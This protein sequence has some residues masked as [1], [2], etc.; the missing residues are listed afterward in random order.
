MPVNPIETRGRSRRTL[1]ATA[2]AV[3]VAVAAVGP[4]AL[5]SAARAADLPPQEAGFTLR[6]YFTPPLDGLCVLKSGQT[7]NVDKLGSTIDLT[8]KSQFLGTD[9]SQPDESF[10][11]EALANLTV[12]TDGTY[13]FRLTSDDGSRLSIDGGTVIDHDGKHAASPKVGS[14]GLAA[15]VH[16][17]RVDY[18]DSGYDAILKLEWKRPGASDWEIVPQSAL[19]TEAGVVR[20][21]APGTKY[22]EGATDTAGD[23]LRLDAVNPNYTLVDIRPAGFDP[24]VSGLDFTDDGRLAL[25]TTGDVSAGGWTPNPRSGELYLLDGVQTATGPADVTA[26][27]VAG[28]LFNPMGVDVIGDKIY[29]AER[30]QLSELTD[31]DGDGQY[32]VKTTVAQWA[33]GGNFHEFAFGLIH[34][35]ENFYLNLSVAINNGGATT[36]PQPGGSHRG[37]SIKVNRATG[38]VTYAAG[39]LRT[40]NGIAF[41]PDGDRFAMDNQGAWNPGNKLVHVQDGHFYNQFITPAGDY[42]DRAVTPPALWIPQNEIGNSPTTPIQLH[43]GPFA[44][45]MLWGDLTYGGLQR[46][47]LEKVDGE[48]QG[49]VFRHSAGFEVGVNR[50][51]ETDDGTLYVGGTGEG[52]NWGESN[53]LRYGLQKLV[54]ISQ[55]SSFEIATMKAVAGGFELTYTHPLSQETVDGIASSYSVRQWRYVPTSQYGG[56]NV[57]EE[58][59][60]VHSANVSEDRRTVTIAIDGLKEGH[61]VHVRSPRPFSSEGGTELWSTEAWYTLNS[62]PGVHTPTTQGWYEAEQQSLLPGGAKVESEHNGYSGTGFVAGFDNLGTG[63]SFAVTVPEAGVYP[64]NVR[65]ANGPHPNPNETKDL[66]LQVNGQDAGTVSL[67]TTNAWNQW[68]TATRN[69]TLAAGLNN[70]VLRYAAGTKGHVN[71]DAL[72][73]GEGRSDVCAA[74]SVEDGYTALFDGTLASFSAW[75]MAGPGSFGRVADDCSL[76][77]SG[78]LGLLWNPTAK[79]EDYSL[80]LDWKLNSDQNGGVFLGFPDPGNDPWVAVNKGYEIQ[81]DA[82][83]DE[84]H[85]TGAVYGF[86]GADQAARDGALKPVGQWN[87]YELVVKDSR[88]QV[89][90]NG[91]LVNDFTSTDPA[92]DITEGFIGVQA[93]GSEDVVYYRDIRVKA[94]DEAPAPLVVSVTSEVRCIAGKATVAVRATNGSDVAADLTVSSPFGERS[95][96]AVAPGASAF[97]TFSAKAKSVPAGEGQVAATSGERHGAASAA[98]AAKSC[99][100]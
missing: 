71:I 85:T 33:D 93:H 20:V 18:F 6:T 84:T 56:P 22:C 58:R 23:G 95:F 3:G 13:E 48:Y 2:V 98:Y 44:G 35:D 72:G 96:S 32:D 59:L 62:I 52:G 67:P 79:L 61:V 7:P 9:G 45:Q 77:S 1:V 78:G 37:S 64:L 50:V 99:A 55:E 10:L 49:A 31:P 89:F 51:I 87:S 97:H 19:S 69:A 26:T 76:R 42:D 39:G 80:K 28:G 53:K 30:D 91:V 74:S 100:P 17:L 73:V 57:D 15:G 63:V 16:A 5:A 11:S 4:P 14:V 24:K 12:D 34:D 60:A 46:G 8:A 41:G 66:A 88:I 68:G 47:F 86:Q 94:L 83:D 40:P 75:K 27:K 70:V 81:I 38:E 92:R 43:T 65:Y 82:S 54:P 21:T 90:L 25:V 29:I 36:D